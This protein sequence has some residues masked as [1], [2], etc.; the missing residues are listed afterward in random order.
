MTEAQ[1]IPAVDMYPSLQSLLDSY[2]T[3]PIPQELIG[4]LRERYNKHGVEYATDQRSPD[5]RIVNACMN[6]DSVQD[7]REE[8][9]D[10]TFNLLVQ[11]LKVREGKGGEVSWRPA[12]ALGYVLRAWAI[13]SQ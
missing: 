6:R 7:A 2:T 5:G 4:E 11:Q 13:I 1:I 10:A 3:L 8:L 12:A 9:V